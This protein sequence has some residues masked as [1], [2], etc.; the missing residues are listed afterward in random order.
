MF[1]CTPA[2]GPLTRK[3][4]GDSAQV[5]VTSKDGTRVPMFVV[6]QKGLKRD[7]TNPTLLYGYGGVFPNP[8]QTLSGSL[9]VC[10]RV[11]REGTRHG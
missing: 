5:F 1:R 7:G 4:P 6:H 8:L 3:T 11:A 9:R 10:G 2:S